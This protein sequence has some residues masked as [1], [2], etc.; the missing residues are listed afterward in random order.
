MVLE[1]LT[2]KVIREQRHEGREGSRLVG[3]LQWS[4]HVCYDG[5]TPQTGSSLGMKERSFQQQSSPGRRANRG[6]SDQSTVSG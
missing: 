6:R 2:G 1:A 4:Q 5:H 3:E